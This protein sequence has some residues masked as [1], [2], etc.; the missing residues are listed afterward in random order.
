MRIL[1]DKTGGFQT[2]IPLK[3]RNKD[4]ELSYLPEVSILEDLKNYAV[5]R[6]FLD[7]FDDEIKNDLNEF[8][9]IPH[10]WKY[11]TAKS[12]LDMP[13]FFHKNINLGICGDYFNHNNL[14]ASLL[15]SELLAEYCTF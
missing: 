8:I 1:Q 11:A 3:F 9:I 10:L 15:S 12:S 13:Y 4:N 5:S 7:N 14:E 6:I 2:F